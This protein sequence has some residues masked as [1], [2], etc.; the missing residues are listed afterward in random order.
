MAL[1]AAN[2]EVDAIKAVISRRDVASVGA[3]ADVVKRE[4][5]VDEL[6]ALNNKRTMRR[7][8]SSLRGTGDAQAM[9]VMPDGS[10][11]AGLIEG[12]WN[13]LLLLYD[14]FSDEGARRGQHDLDQRP[15]CRVARRSR[16]YSAL[17]CV[18]E[19]R[20]RLR[21]DVQRY[22]RKEAHCDVDLLAQLVGESVR[23]GWHWCV[24]SLSL[25]IK[26]IV[27][28]SLR[29]FVGDDGEHLSRVV[30]PVLEVPSNRCCR[31]AAN[32]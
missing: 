17:C 14:S 5:V 3:L 7:S 11:E 31:R 30:W 32:V 28:C 9:Q 24:I 10:F 6:S 29:H 13:L 1:H 4:R 18:A 19:T 16:N 27:V 12:V 21:F 23:P 20:S 22:E 2:N 26:H 15:F 8:I 25:S